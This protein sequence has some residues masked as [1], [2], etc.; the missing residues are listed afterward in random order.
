MLYKIFVFA[1]IILLINNKSGIE[2][3]L[4]RIKTLR[5]KIIYL[6]SI[7]LL[8][9]LVVTGITLYTIS[10]NQLEEELI[11]ELKH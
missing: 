5:N 1:T 3:M 4:K 2:S 7:L 11:L 6:T 8:V 9:P 10:K